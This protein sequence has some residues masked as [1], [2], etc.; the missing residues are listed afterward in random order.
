MAWCW[1]NATESKPQNVSK[2]LR[3]TQRKK[4]KTENI[5]VKNLLETVTESTSFL[6]ASGEIDFDFFYNEY[7]ILLTFTNED[8]D[9]LKNELPN[10]TEDQLDVLATTLHEEH[11]SDNRL[12]DNY[13]IGYI[14]TI[15]PDNLA[16][17]IFNCFL[18]Y[19]ISE[20]KIESIDLLNSIEEKI[21]L[22]YDKKY[23]SEESEYKFWVNYIKETKEKAVC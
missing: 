4:M 15:A 7:K 21:N 2:Q 17:S 14:F 3:K 16:S 13:F 1:Y 12:N 10:W 6:Q 22:L 20:N 18:Y 11:G 23:I 9:C 19:F 5:K 8:W